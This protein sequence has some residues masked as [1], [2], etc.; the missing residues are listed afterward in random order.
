MMWKAF[1]DAPIGVLLVDGEGRC[2]FANTFCCT[3]FGAAEGDIQGSGWATFLSTADRQ[4]MMNA[5][6]KVVAGEEQQGHC[7]VAI[8]G[9]QKNTR[10]WSVD[11]F[12]VAGDHSGAD[13]IVIYFREVNQRL[14]VAEITEEVQRERMLQETQDKI[15]RTNEL[16]NISQ[17]LSSTGGWEYDLISGDVS[18]TDQIYVIFGLPPEAVYPSFEANIHLFTEAGRK[19]VVD[20][21]EN[22][23]VDMKP[24][25]MELEVNTPQDEFKW[26]RVRAVP[27]VKDNQVVKLRGALMDITKEKLEAIE[28]RKAKEMAERAAQVKSDFLSVMSHEI[29]TP[30]VGIIGSSNQLKQG[31]SADRDETINNL[32]FS[33]EHLLRLV[34]DVL[35]FNKIESG[36]LRLIQ[37]EVD[38][39]E[40]VA[41]IKNQFQAMAE[42]KGIAVVVQIDAA[43][44]SR[45]MGDPTRLSQI[46]YNLVSNAIK[47]T[48]EG[49]VTIAITE[50]SHTDS[51]TTL[52]FSVKDTGSGIPEAF[53]EEIFN[54]FR[55]LN[56]LPD[57]HY[58]GFGLGLTIT[59]R[60]IELHDSQ[61]L[62]RSSP[63]NGAEFYFDLCFTLP[64]AASPAASNPPPSA[65]NPGKLRNMPVLLVEDNPISTTVIRQQLE[66][67]GIVPDCA[68]D[69][70]EALRYLAGTAYSV[71]LVDLHMPK[72]DGYVLS[73]IICREYP[74]TQIIILT[75][76]IMAETRLKL[77]KMNIL[78]ILNK[79]F[80]PGDLVTSLS[81]VNEP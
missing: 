63:G 41:N 14:I 39:M 64:L 34:N 56:Q 52:H 66:G 80:R 3:L 74:D 24:Y 5:L 32:L 33:S 16:L 68:V 40:L 43:V 23:K 15:E 31:H 58:T 35:D 78:D 19:V 73:E 46:L 21:L 59:K 9:S 13:Q 51:D 30:L 4:R 67:L 37:A 48:N 70:E 60:L 17:E 7:N 8:A 65:G 25:T 11:L 38:L 53:H 28:L 69:G 50:L 76:D 36:Q 62:L 1:Q 54:D 57:Q 44:P 72:M 49:T 45:I 18:W 47:H 6:Q 10:Y 81:K 75:A 22:C 27:V 20:A 77:A 55:Q 12:G 2:T 26:V 42:A 79:P 61:I 29:R 71:A